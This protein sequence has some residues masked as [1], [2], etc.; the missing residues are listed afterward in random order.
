MRSCHDIC[1][2]V[3]LTLIKDHKIIYFTPSSGIEHQ[4][5]C[6]NHFSTFNIKGQ[7]Q[8]VIGTLSTLR[9]LWLSFIFKIARK[10]T[11]PIHTLTFL[12]SKYTSHN[13][14]TPFPIISIIPTSNPSSYVVLWVDLGLKLCFNSM[15]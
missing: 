6:K 2:K 3:N 4:L 8:K 9:F 10:N 1:Q 15:H 13:L 5:S 11:Y 12:T 7:S 14:Y